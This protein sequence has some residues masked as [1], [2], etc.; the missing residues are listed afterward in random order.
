MSAEDPAAPTRVLSPRTGLLYL[1]IVALAIGA[2]FGGVELLF[3]FAPALP[4][5]GFD[6]G[7]AI[8]DPLDVVVAMPIGGLRPLDE[9][10]PWPAD[11]AGELARRF[12]VPSD[13]VL[14]V[15]RGEE[16]RGYPLR[17]LVFHEVIGDVLGGEPI[18]VVH[19]PLSGLSAAFGRSVGGETLRFGPSGLLIDSHPLL[20]DRPPGDDLARLA[21]SSLWSPLLGRAVA[22]PRAGTELPLLPCE[23]TTWED[24]RTR[25]P[26]STI[27][28]PPYEYRKEYRKDL[29]NQ[30]VGAGKLRYPVDPLPALS[31]RSLFAPML[32]VDVEDEFGR[33]LLADAIP[34]V[35]GRWSGPERELSAD[36]A[37]GIDG[38][39]PRIV[40]RSLGV[41]TVT[42]GKVRSV[43]QAYW[44]AWH[45]AEE[46]LARISGRGAGTPPAPPTPRR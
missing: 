35:V 36:G 46:E 6:L 17:V 10:P 2:L 44:F 12:L 27:P 39:P 25:F 31:S 29:Y 21:E 20:F 4:H 9:P 3:D 7:G 19:H 16:T 33:R 45:A 15:T 22:G 32:I 1:G 38:I 42:G 41:V 23:V 37:R 30:Y 11:R 8:V 40:D 18:A 24:F 14:V 13:L 26:D 28:E 43:R 5:N 34:E